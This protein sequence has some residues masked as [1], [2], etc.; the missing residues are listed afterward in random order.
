MSRGTVLVV[1]D[2][3]GMRETIA[4]I[5]TAT[6]YDV[7]TATDGEDA[8][9]HLRS[10][11]FSVVVMDIRMPVR[12]GISVAREL[13]G[14]PPPVVFM[15]AYVADEHLAA[16]A[17]TKAFAVMHKPVPPPRLLDVVARAMAA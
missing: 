10:G 13:G 8:L 4:D 2:E 9:R 1:D 7:T 5:L 11:T 17:E 6:G 14:P 16:A 3:V 12:D 15:S